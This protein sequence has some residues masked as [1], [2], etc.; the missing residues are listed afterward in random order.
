MLLKKIGYGFGKLISALFL[1]LKSVICLYPVYWMITLSFKTAREAG[2]DVYSFPA[3][4][5]EVGFSNFAT[6]L[7]RMDYG[8]AMMNSLIY[9]TVITVVTV[10]FSCTAAYAMTRMHFK[11]ANIIYKYFLLG[12]SIPGMCL[13]VP[14]FMII[15]GMGLFGTRWAIIVLGIAAAAAGSLLMVAF[16]RSIPSEL[17][18]AAAIDGC[19]C[20]RCFFSIMFPIFK[21]AVA[22][23]CML[24]FLRMWNEFGYSSILC[25]ND[26]L[27]PLV[28]ETQSFFGSQYAKEWNNIGASVVL[29]AGPAILVYVFANKGIENAMTAGAILK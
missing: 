20:H 23:R 2:R 24:E 19:N 5:F 17:E 16:M 10:F 27:R 3:T 28:M 8:H 14:V 4:P 11:F 18:E 25:M 15:K 9:S 29:S 12:L 6:V 13:M 22:T 21:P 1:I 7:D 26:K